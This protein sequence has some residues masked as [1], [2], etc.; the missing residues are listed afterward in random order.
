M[1]S[2]D[3][4]QQIDTALAKAVTVTVAKA[5]PAHTAATFSIRYG[6]EASPHPGEPCVTVQM[7]D[8]TATVWA[9]GVMPPAVAAA[10]VVALKYIAQGAR[11][12]VGAK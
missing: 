7:G 9:S 4:E 6:D 10:F 2:R 5:V 3:T 8:T 11:E 1:G 12:K